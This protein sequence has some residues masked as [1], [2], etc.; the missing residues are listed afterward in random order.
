MD[1]P[2]NHID[3]AGRTALEEMLSEFS[4]ALVCVSHDRAFL[5]SLCDRI[6]EVS[7]GEVR[8][9][10]GNYTEFRRAHLE[11]VEEAG[12]AKRE[13]EKRAKKALE[14]QRVRKE[15]SKNSKKKNKNPWKLKQVEARIIEL[16]GELEKLRE[17]LG[18]EEVYRDQTMAREVQFKI[19]EFERELEEANAEWEQWAT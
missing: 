8:E 12:T 11:E 3:L 9:Y 13:E 17:S 16:E 15:N 18:S 4:G 1:E 10:R 5:D 14:E 19:S 2:T 6:V 7:R